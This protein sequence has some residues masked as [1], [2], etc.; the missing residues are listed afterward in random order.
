MA[1]ADTAAFTTARA[2]GRA[3]RRGWLVVIVASLVVSC[4][5]APTD[6]GAPTS[7]SRPTP[8]PFDGVDRSELTEQETDFL[9]GAEEQ[10][11]DTTTPNLIEV[12]G[13]FPDESDARDFAD[14]IHKVASNVE[15]EPT[16]VAEG[17]PTEWR[18]SAERAMTL[19]AENLVDWMIEFGQLVSDAGGEPTPGW[20][21][22]GEAS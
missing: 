9:Q 12:T 10:G 22:H 15:V 19:T 18:V 4:S 21:S 1:S 16:E 5:S 20:E 13:L 17:E 2:T 14:S 8:S 6:E 11:L 3:R 7:T